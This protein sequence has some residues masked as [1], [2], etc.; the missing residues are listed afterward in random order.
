MS[1]GI[2]H[3]LVTLFRGSV[4]A[5]RVIHGVRLLERNGLIVPVDGRGRGV[6]EFLTVRLFT[7]FQ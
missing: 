6:Y 1:V 5:D 2:C 3:Q 4:N 7:G